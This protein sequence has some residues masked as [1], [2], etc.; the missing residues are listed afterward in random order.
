ML[1]TVGI[2]VA[3]P[4]K[5][6]GVILQDKILLKHFDKYSDNVKKCFVLKSV[7]RSLLFVYLL[8]HQSTLSMWL[9]LFYFI[10][11]LF[12]RPHPQQLSLSPIE[13]NYHIPAWHGYRAKQGH[14]G[15]CMDAHRPQDK[16][17]KLNK[18]VFWSVRGNEST[19]RE[20]KHIHGEHAERDLK[21]DP[22]AARQQCIQ[23][24][25]CAAIWR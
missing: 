23:L 21:N 18:C 24:C 11:C 15:S 13:T 22:V 10:P 3:Y 16:L 8:C 12:H 1:L 9:L 6:K 2:I 4:F 5:I 20:P 25:H 17:E 19:W 14:T 7:P